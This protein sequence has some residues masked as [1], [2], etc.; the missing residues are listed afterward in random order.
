MSADAR[1]SLALPFMNASK[2][3]RNPGLFKSGRPWVSQSNEYSMNSS[4]RKSSNSSSLMLWSSSDSES[5][6]EARLLCFDFFLFDDRLLLPLDE[7]ADDAI[8]GLLEA[9]EL[10][11]PARTEVPRVWP[12]WV[13]SLPTLASRRSLEMAALSLAPASSEPALAPPMPAVLAMLLA[14]PPAPAMAPSCGPLAVPPAPAMAPPCGPLAS[15]SSPSLSSAASASFRRTV[16]PRSVALLV[17]AMC[18]SQLV[19]ALCSADAPHGT[20]LPP[21]LSSA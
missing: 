15:P 6:S 20:S 12:A 16:D 4:T 13:A 2:K 3:R 5:D 19:L 7:A 21:A 10:L 8:D 11:E 1:T 14:V 17:T 18:H 9:R